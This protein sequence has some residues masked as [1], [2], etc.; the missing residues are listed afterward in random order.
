M[1]TPSGHASVAMFTLLPMVGEELGAFNGPPSDQS[2]GFPVLRVA[3]FHSEGKRS[4]ER[5]KP[6]RTKRT[7]HMLL[8]KMSYRLLS[9]EI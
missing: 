9:G 8:G 2:V 5:T 3:P 6:P 1:R 7:W 4:N